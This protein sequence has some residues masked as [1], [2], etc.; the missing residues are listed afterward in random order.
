MTMDTRI[1][2]ESPSGRIIKIAGLIIVRQHPQT[3]KD[4][5]FATLEDERGLLDM[6]LHKNIYER[7]HDIFVTEPFQIITGK[8]QHDTNTSNLII[9]KI[10]KFVPS[11]GEWSL[12]IFTESKKKVREAV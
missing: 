7:Y 10:E 4:T 9:R 12:M 5:V 11:S 2:K 3:A 8:M 6:I 1:A